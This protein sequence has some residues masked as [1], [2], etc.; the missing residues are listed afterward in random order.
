MKKNLVPIIY[1]F[2]TLL[3]AAGSPGKND[4]PQISWKG[5]A[6]EEY[7]GARVQI[8]Y[9]HDGRMILCGEFSRESVYVSA[10][11]SA[12][13]RIESAGITVTALTDC[14][15]ALRVWT[16]D[17]F[18]QTETVKLEEDDSYTLKLDSNTIWV[19]RWGQEGKETKQ[20]K[21]PFRLIQI[22]LLR[23]PRTSTA[24]LRID[25]VKIRPLIEQEIK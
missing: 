15:I 13:S 6:G 23:M 24:A 19:A 14:Q 21:P 3:V 22:N 12:P 18:F 5:G 20:A 8:R 17:G 2:S 16:Q 1:L 10:A 7:P 4:S 9:G 25:E 11:I